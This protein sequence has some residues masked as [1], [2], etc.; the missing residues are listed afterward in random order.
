MEVEREYAVL[1][2]G[3]RGSEEGSS[4]VRVSAASRGIDVEKVKRISSA[5]IIYLIGIRK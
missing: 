4:T 2:K 1:A 5:E 3:I